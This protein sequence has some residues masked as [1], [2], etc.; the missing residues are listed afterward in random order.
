MKP[1]PDGAHR[2]A[3]ALVLLVG[4]VAGLPLAAADPGHT[5]PHGPGTGP[6]TPT[7]PGEEM[8]DPDERD[9]G[10]PERTREPEPPQRCTPPSTG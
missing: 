10:A 3:M 1:L 5:G 9:R 7:P 2:L 4:A 8:A 6:D